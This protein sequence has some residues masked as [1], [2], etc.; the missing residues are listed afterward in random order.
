M[1]AL[2]LCDLLG[3][4][5]LIDYEGQSWW[6]LTICV[7][8]VDTLQVDRAGWYIASLLLQDSQELSCLSGTGLD[9]FS[10]K[11]GSLGSPWI[12]ACLVLQITFLWHQPCHL[13]ASRK[14]RMVEQMCFSVSLITKPLTILSI[15]CY[16]QMVLYYPVKVKFKASCHSIH[17]KNFLLVPL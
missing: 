1:L 9:G 7:N 5:R 15:L 16:S 13:L 12:R 3:S 8:Q 4:G 11:F 10:S 6:E 2:L 14:K 17:P